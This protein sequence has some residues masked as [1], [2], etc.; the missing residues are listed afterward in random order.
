MRGHLHVCKTYKQI[1]KHFYWLGTGKDVLEYCWTCHTCQMVGKLN[2]S[3][4]AAPL[5]LILAFKEPFCHVLVD[6]VGPLPKMK[7][8]NQ[9]I[10]TI[11]CASTQF[12]EV[13]PL[14]KISAG[15]ITTALLN[16]FSIVR[17]LKIVQTDQ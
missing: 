10:L 3:I 2:Q 9:H 15:K 11:M 4:P 6:C 7:H 12:P 8:G 17:L 13:I 1:A 5:H 16:F 14:R